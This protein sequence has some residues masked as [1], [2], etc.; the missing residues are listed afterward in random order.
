MR[1]TIYG[2]EYHSIGESVM[3]TAELLLYLKYQMLL[4][5]KIFDPISDLENLT[6]ARELCHFLPLTTPIILLVKQL[7]YLEVYNLD[8]KGISC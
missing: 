1:Q 4:M 3:V 5:T 7:L 8:C 2:D 6:T